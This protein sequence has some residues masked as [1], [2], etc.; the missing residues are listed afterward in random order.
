MKSS[1]RCRSKAE[2]SKSIAARE[3]QHR[4]PAFFRTPHECKEFRAEFVLFEYN[5]SKKR[6]REATRWQE[7]MCWRKSCWTTRM[8]SQTSG[9]CSSPAGGRSSR[10]RTFVNGYPIHIIEVARLPEDVIAQLQSDF[11]SVADF[12][13]Q[14]RLHYE[15]KIPFHPLPDEVRHI[16]EVLELLSIVSGDKRIWE[17]ARA[18]NRK[19]R[20]DMGLS[21]GLRSQKMEKCIDSQNLVHNQ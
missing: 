12:F 14:E 3:H 13:R 5:R 19:E 4:L 20:S 10:K 7:K 17:A 8:C 18:W 11:K 9:T 16:N 2:R 6:Q 21:F 1:T 15:K